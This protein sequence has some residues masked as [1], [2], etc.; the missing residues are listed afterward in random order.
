MAIETDDL[1]ALN[2]EDWVE[3]RFPS[4]VVVFRN[5]CPN[6]LERV[7]MALAEKK[8]AV[9]TPDERARLG[10]VPAKASKK[11]LLIAPQPF[12]L[13]RGTP[14]NVRAIAETLGKL[15]YDVHLLVYPLGETIEIPGVTIH[16]SWPLP[17]ISS[18]PIGPS[19]RKVLL[20]L[21]FCLKAFGLAFG[22]RFSVIHG[23]EEGGFIAWALGTLWRTPYVFDLD[24]WMSEQ[25]SDS[26]FLKSQVLLKVIARLE[27]H[28]VKKAAAVLT[29]CQAL[30]DRVRV[31][32]SS[33]PLYQ[34]E[35]FPLEP[36]AGANKELPDSLRKEFGLVGKRVL[37][38]TG[39]FE[40]YQGI[41][42]LLQAFAAA[43]RESSS[44]SELSLL[45]VGGGSPE[46]PHVIRTRDQAARLG[47]EKSVVFA[48]QRPAEEMHA[49]MSFA[50]LLLSPRTLG[51][52]TP[53]KIY[54]YMASGTPIVAT[55][56]SSHTQVLN[57]QSAFLGKATEEGLASAIIDALD[58]SPSGI[59]ERA[60]RASRAKELVETRYSRKEFTRR[61]GEMYRELT[62]KAD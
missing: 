7:F 60:S 4:F 50:D 21:P 49:F 41:D 3:R 27:A 58:D 46:N 2:F 5:I 36:A 40:P 47:L 37:L 1:E 24:S 25:I 38:Y 14:I 48:G 56:I 29:V 32:C 45:L 52:N 54:T 55:C 31:L 6:L 15:G 9:S 16:R 11:I 57:E 33:V 20:D 44:Q 53:L 59:E 51:G 30:S 34:I 17:G 61:L 8:K 13:N 18:V 10:E 28:C 12:F 35:D 62:D 42:L 22:R 39:N 26:G 43:R 19:W 23:I